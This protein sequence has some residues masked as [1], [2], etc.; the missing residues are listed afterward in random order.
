MPALTVIGAQPELP[1]PVLKLTVP[2]A[3][4]GASVLGLALVEI[5]L[6]PSKLAAFGLEFSDLHQQRFTA[7][8]ALVVSYFLC[9]FVVYAFS[10]YVS[11]RRQ[12]KIRYSRYLQMQKKDPP[13]PPAPAH[14]ILSASGELARPEVPGP[15]PVYRGTASWTAA[16]VAS[17][18]RAV[19][20]FFLPIVFSLY[21]LQSLLLYGR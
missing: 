20:D 6:V 8:Y 9:A 13:V 17:R 19:F 16:L 21:V 18:M 3:L 10:D 5:P 11:W 12:E 14:P 1:A 15:S 4:L 2:V 7:I